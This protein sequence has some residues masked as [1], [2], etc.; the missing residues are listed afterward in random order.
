M[1]VVVSGT[2]ASGKSALI[3]DFATR[4]PDWTVLG[5]P[6]EFVDAAGDEPDAGTYF[7]QLRFAAYRL[8]ETLPG[9]MIAERGPLDFLAYLDA[10]A[11]L[12][13]PTRSSALFRRG[14]PLA[15]EA[16]AGVDLLVLLPLN[17]ADRIG[18]GDDEDPALRDAMDTALLDLA[19]DPALTGGATVVELGGDPDQRLR[20]LE[21]AIARQG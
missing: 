4:H 20:R 5:D 8:I 1:R 12:R 2:H 19:D 9:P 10:L 15:V 16:M 11:T 3:G 17:S 21:E 7:S 14:V 6:F 18:V 13:R